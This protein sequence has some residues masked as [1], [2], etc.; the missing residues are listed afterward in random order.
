MFPGP[1]DFLPAAR[2]VSGITWNLPITDLRS[3]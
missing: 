3:G 1:E 2:F